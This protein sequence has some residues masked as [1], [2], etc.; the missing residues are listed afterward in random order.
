[1]EFDRYII[2]KS[3]QPRA[4][5]ILETPQMNK[6][7]FT[8][9]D[10]R[11]ADLGARLHPL[12]RGARLPFNRWGKSSST[13]SLESLYFLLDRQLSDKTVAYGGNTFLPISPM[14]ISLRRPKVVF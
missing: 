9:Q 5:T 11:S 8:D 3:D 2:F 14:R 10:L 1:M 4:G 6:L 7:Q 12:L 13:I